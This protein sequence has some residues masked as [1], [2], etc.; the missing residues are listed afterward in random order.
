ME[1]FA[2]PDIIKISEEICQTPLSEAAKM[3]I[4]KGKFFVTNINQN[5]AEVPIKEVT[6]FA[7]HACHYCLD[8]TNELADISCGSIGSG[9][10]WNT[11]VVRSEKGEKLFNAALEENYFQI[12][13]IPED[14]P[15]GIPLIEKL[16]SGKK[17]RNFGGLL[18]HLE[19]LPPYYYNSLKDIMKVEEQ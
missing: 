16:S 1:T 18:Q 15:F 7:R 5:V 19:G 12:N 10:G 9:N 17:T 2:Y 4:N 8:L 11:V 3:N 14:Q 6:G 13:D